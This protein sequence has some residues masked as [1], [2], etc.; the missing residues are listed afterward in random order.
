M[1]REWHSIDKHRLSKYL[2]LVRK[3]HEQSLRY[4]KQLEW[5]PEVLDNFNKLLIEGPL[6]PSSPSLGIKFQLVQVHLDEIFKVAK[7]VWFFSHYSKLTYQHSSQLLHQLLFPFY[8][9]FAET[10]DKRIIERL[11]TDIFDALL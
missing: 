11:K 4:C 10:N 9:L 3:T 8:R 7:E 6:N 5:Q 2:S 1:E